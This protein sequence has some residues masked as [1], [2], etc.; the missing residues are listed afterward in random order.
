MNRARFGGPL[1]VLAACCPLPAA[2]QS[3]PRLL[4][5]TGAVVLGGL[6]GVQAGDLT[7]DLGTAQPV[8]SVGAVRR[9][10]A[11]GKALAPVDPKAKIDEPRVDARGV[12][13][14]RGRWVFRALP[15][16]SYDLVVVTSDRVRVE[17]FR[18]PPIAE[19]D[20][21]LPPDAK[22][23]DE[24]AREAIVKHIARAPQ[25]EN[26]VVPLFLAG[27]DKQ[28]R[29]L[30]QLVRDRPTSF[31]ADAGAP[32]ATVRHEVWQYTNQYGG[33]VKDRRTEVLDRVLLPRAE[34]HRWTWVWDPR[35]GGI[36][37]AD[38]PVPRTC[39]LPARL[40]PQKDRGWFPD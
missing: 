4:L 14:G 20:P 7:V 34:F 12:S 36:E 3:F 32:V 5:V 10:D 2:C 38:R 6:P 35:L 9:W 15:P 26:K 8:S 19:F 28:V 18:Y 24:E 21:F 31:D 16:G 33:W 17:G 11:E 27:D 39:P 25:Y 13:L 23:P 1:A 40:D 29:I 22:P 30:V 37:V